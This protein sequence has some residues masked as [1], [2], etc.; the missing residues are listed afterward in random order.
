VATVRAA[1]PPVTAALRE[2][3]ATVTA[4]RTTIAAGPQLLTAVAPALKAARA[5]LPVASPAVRRLGPALANMVPMARYL[6]PRANTIA[7][8]FSNTADLGSHGD[9]KGDW[10]RFLVMFD[11]ATATGAAPGPAGNSYTAP[12][13]AA[14]NAPYRPG[15]YPRLV[16]FGP[17][18]S[19]GGAARSDG[20]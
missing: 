13:D 15:D 2:L 19:G 18:L 17:A 3:P 16:P 10:A 14:H 11:P 4:A 12:N 1:A 20:P 7:A 8:W 5:L 9:A 6:E